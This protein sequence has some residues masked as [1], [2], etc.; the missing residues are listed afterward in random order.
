MASIM[1]QTQVI[2]YFPFATSSKCHSLFS[3]CFPRRLSTTDEG[4]KVWISLLAESS[5]TSESQ[6]RAL[7]ALTNLWEVVIKIKLCELCDV[8]TQNQGRCQRL[9]FKDST[10]L[11][12]AIYL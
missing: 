11:H 1:R 2:A 12:F 7:L 9:F 8:F 4:F 10:G 6:F 3:T 5:L